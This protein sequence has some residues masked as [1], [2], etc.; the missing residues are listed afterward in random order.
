MSM[1]FG[2]TGPLDIC[3]AKINPTFLYLKVGPNIKTIKDIFFE[4]ETLVRSKAVGKYV[5]LV[6][7]SISVFELIDG[8]LVYCEKLESDK[9]NRIKAVGFQS[10]TGNDPSGNIDHPDELDNSYWIRG[11]APEKPRSR[12][13]WIQLSR[14]DLNTLAGSTFSHLLP[15]CWPKLKTVTRATWN[16]C[17][18]FVYLSDT[19]IT[20]FT[21]NITRTELKS[22]AIN[23]I[24]YQLT[25]V[26][27]DG[28]CLFN[29]VSRFLGLDDD[30]TALRMIVANYLRQ[31]VEEFRPFIPVVASTKPEIFS[32]VL[33]PN[34]TIVSD[35]INKLADAIKNGGR[36]ADNIEITIL[37]RALGRPINVVLP[38][39]AIINTAD[40]IDSDPIFVYYNGIDHYD[41]LT[42]L[43]PI[44]FLLGKRTR[45]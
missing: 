30:P 34:L 19:F 29:A 5:V 45:A 21:D 16:T 33:G 12:S 26:V 18:N 24:D 13:K 2:D 36:W 41:A 4:V 28:S 3:P 40:L 44:S 10:K 11:R 35:D 27:G 7:F 38:S 6:R 14:S 42:P 32:F 31:N 43:E 15:I 25:K 23:G 8:A 22:I 37:S 20:K 1:Y 9:Y 39:E 17:D